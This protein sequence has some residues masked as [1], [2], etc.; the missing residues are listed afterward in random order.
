VVL[1]GYAA[2]HNLSNTQSAIIAGTSCAANA[3]GRLILGYLADYIGHINMYILAS[4][5][6]GLLCML[7]WPFLKTF[8][9]I[10]TFAILFGFTCGMFFTLAPPITA[11]IVGQKNISS[12][13]SIVFIFSAI[14]GAGL[15]IASAIQNVSPG[16]GYI[17]IQLFS[18]SVHL[19]GVLAC[20]VLKI[21]L[22]GSLFSNS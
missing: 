13:F 10:I 6:C 22:N 12:G 17:G 7:L 18:G 19:L 15:P 11:T 3:I 9:T 20:I 1:L 14:S 4:T 16:D 21:K 8:E 5:V 2:Q